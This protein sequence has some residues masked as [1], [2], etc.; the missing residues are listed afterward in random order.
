M[1]AVCNLSFALCSLNSCV[2]LWNLCLFILS[3]CLRWGF[4][5]LCELLFFLLC[6]VNLL[7]Y[8]FLCVSEER[9][10]VCEK[11]VCILWVLWTSLSRSADEMF[12]ICCVWSL[13][14]TLQGFSGCVCVCVCVAWVCL[15]L[16][17]LQRLHSLPL[18]SLFVSVVWLCCALC[19]RISSSSIASSPLVCV[20]LPQSLLECECLIQCVH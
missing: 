1:F 11:V 15:S 14:L 9:R 2:W 6:A 17:T 18:S 12:C 13:F 4:N 19:A 3:L 7:L 5:A 10:V 8:F 20:L 16:L